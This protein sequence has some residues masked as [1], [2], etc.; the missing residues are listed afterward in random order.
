MAKWRYKALINNKEV[1][2]IVEANT[3]GAAY[4]NAL[5]KLPSSCAL[6]YTPDGIYELEK[7]SE[8]NNVASARDSVALPEAREAESNA[9]KSKI[10][11]ILEPE[12]V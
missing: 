9:K 11:R 1:S 5:C 10:Y 12:T 7:V 8:T 4:I 3:Y 6:G 2:G